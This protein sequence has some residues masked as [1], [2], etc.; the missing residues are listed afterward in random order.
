MFGFLG[1]LSGGFGRNAG[2]GDRQQSHADAGGFLDGRKSDF[3]WLE[4]YLYGGKYPWGGGLGSG[5]DY[6]KNKDNPIGELLERLRSGDVP[7]S[8]AYALSDPRRGA[9]M[10]GLP[11][12]GSGP[13]RG[14]NAQGFGLNGVMRRLDRWDSRKLEQDPA[15][16][17]PQWSPP[18]PSM[19]TSFGDYALPESAQVNPM[20]Y[21]G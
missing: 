12:I 19:A 5:D 18:D 15:P 6:Q 9:R 21:M 10:L 11:F 8:L 7:D 17:K 1:G 3:S 2:H 20:G 13:P 16:P 4:D 14:L